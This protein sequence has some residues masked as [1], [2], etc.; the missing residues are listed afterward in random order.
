MVQ[1]VRFKD[2][3]LDGSGNPRA[4]PLAS[5]TVKLED[6][7]VGFT[8]SHISYFWQGDG[9]TPYILQNNVYGPMSNPL[10]SDAYVY[11]PIDEPPAAFDIA[12]T[13]SPIT[14]SNNRFSHDRDAY[15]YSGTNITQSGSYYAE[16]P[17]I[18]FKNL[19]FADGF[20]VR[21]VAFW[22][23]Q[24]EQTDKAGQYIPYKVG[25]IVYYYDSNG[26]TKFFQCLA[27]HVSTATT[28]YDPNTAT[29]QW[30]ALTWGGRGMPPL[31]VRL[32]ANTYYNYRGMGLS[33]NE[34]NTTATD[35]TAPTITLFGVND[36]NIPQGQAFV[37][38]GWQATDNKD[39]NLSSQVVAGW[40]GPA[41]NVSVPGE[42]YR[43]YRVVDAAGNASEPLTRTVTVS[44]AGITLSKKAQINM[45]LNGA[46]NL[47]GW[48]DI[49]NNATG[50]VNNSGT[51]VGITNTNV[52]DTTGVD[53]N[54]DLMIEDNPNAGGV[55]EHFGIHTNSAGVAIGEFP[56]A[57]TKQGLK[58]R[59]P[60]EDPCLFVLTGL[61]PAKYY[62]VRYTGYIQASST[63]P[64]C[65][66]ELSEAISGRKAVIT[67]K[68]NTNQV[69][70]LRSLKPNAS[71]QL[72]LRFSTETPGGQPNLSGLILQEKSG[73]G[74]NAYSALF[75][76]NFQAS[77]SVSDYWNAASP[78]GC[79]F[80]DISKDVNGGTWSINGS[81]QLQ[82]V[83]SGGA[84]PDNGA[85]FT[86]YTNFAATPTV[87]KVKF[88]LGASGTSSQNDLMIL[89]IGAISGWTD[90][91]SG[92]PS[93]S[94]FGR[95]NIDGSGT[96][97]KFEMNGTQSAAYA[98]NGTMYAVTYYLNKSGTTQNYTGP[99][100]SAKTIGAN[101]VSLWVGTVCLFD[102]VVALN[103]ASS[104]LT[105][106]RVRFQFA[107]SHTWKFDNFVIT[108]A[109]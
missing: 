79:Q 95:L 41:I 109:F 7:F 64:D 92:T 75:E 83:R 26:V 21:R 3:G 15:S 52:F 108:N 93:A 94:T 40:S 24:Y 46:I 104:A 20:D 58:I 76:Q 47:A 103:G 5:K 13:N 14:L 33:Y 80:N 68:N 2:P 32:A 51:T 28:T 61:N 25:D 36:M 16:P 72:S 65:E 86:R 78:M 62:D 60:F 18:K 34:A 87:L 42:Y 85:G 50:L 27:D 89:D 31:D 39:G 77:T 74:W 59:D 53:T 35:L 54:W 6:N 49:G 81:G 66:A 12:N 37:D 71:G 11:N 29:A 30:Q 10:S 105:D 4:F 17:V 55:S 63:I 88:D 101:N 106:L 38:P 56:A 96:N 57:V 23:T 100:G 69:G 48:T 19:G 90:Y 70:Q 98:A 1:G 82:L 43:T 91:N 8:R 67:V 73:F 107:D 84:S 102:N 45:H 9:I 22:A 44:S 99:D 97:I